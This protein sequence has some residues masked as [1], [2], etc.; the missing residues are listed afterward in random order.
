MEEKLN[1]IIIAAVFI[2]GLIF[3]MGVVDRFYL[4]IFF[5]FLIILVYRCGL[6]RI[7]E[8]KFSIT[9]MLILIIFCLGVLR[10]YFFELDYRSLNGFPNIFAG[11]AEVIGIEGEYKYLIKLKKRLVCQAILK[12]EEELLPGMTIEIKGNLKIPDAEANRDGFSYRDY[13]K[14]RGIKYLLNADH[15][16]IINQNKNLRYYLFKY[17]NYYIKELEGDLGSRIRYIESIFLGDVDSLKNQEVSTW[18]NMGILHLQAVSGSQVG[19]ALDILLFLFVITPK[20]G[21]FKYILFLIPLI[22][23]GLMTAT[24]SVWRVIIYL[25][26][27]KIFQVFK[28]EK[29]EML[30]LML[31]SLILININPGVIFQIS[32]QLSYIISTGLL[33]Y[34]SHIKKIEN[35]FFKLLAGGVLSVVLSWPILMEYFQEVS[36]MSIIFTPVISPLIQLIIFVS[37]IL[38]IVPFLMN[39]L[40]PLTVFL[41]I[42]LIILDKTT[43]FFSD[44]NLPVFYGKPWGFIFIILF[45]LLVAFWDNLIF[46]EGYR[47]MFIIILII[48][49]IYNIS[50]DRFDDKKVVIT[51]INVGQG[52]SVLIECKEVGEVI[53]ID[54]GV[55]NEFLDMG[56]SAVLPYLK[57]NGIRKIDL[58]ISTHSDI[59]H[60]GGLETIL[61]EMEV[62]NIWIPINQE[63]DYADWLKIYDGRIQEIYNKMVLE[64][65]EMKIR[66]FNPDKRLKGDDPNTSSIVLSLDYGSSS[67]LLTADCD[68]GILDELARKG[69]AFDVVKAPHHGS[70]YSYREDIYD[71]LEAKSVIF[72]VG[73]NTYGHPSKKIIR[74][75]QEDGIIYYRT[76]MDKNIIVTMNETWLEINGKKIEE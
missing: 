66:V 21:F 65:G 64:A 16:Y 34:S 24:P 15:V 76:D 41:N 20:K 39:L 31:S 7:F 18:R 10:G 51:F 63:K 57:R 22:L 67:I 47:K 33:L 14:Y 44:V 12:T 1:S 49:S 23:Y 32:F 69:S 25:I 55:K 27:I 36:L 58:L 8:E 73:Q 11:E 19:A 74:E 56:K 38:M 6:L 72:S 53:L 46:R 4:S 59:D 5:L 62:S 26:I 52:D 61:K 60:R 28:I 2:T 68:L 37:T 71:D 70:A 48:L 75:L 45:Y 13:L 17:Q 50:V 43:L 30:A 54:G 40:R 29:F 3:I 35:Q 42:L 9:L